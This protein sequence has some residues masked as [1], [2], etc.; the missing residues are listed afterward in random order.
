MAERVATC[1]L[2]ALGF[3]ALALSCSGAPQ[4]K[5]PSKHAPSDA[6]EEARVEKARVERARVER[7][8]V[9]KAGDQSFARMAELTGAELN[10]L[11]KDPFRRDELE[12]FGRHVYKAKGCTLCHS[13]KKGIDGG[14]GPSHGGLYG[15]RR[16]FRDGTILIAADGSYV[17]ESILEPRKRIV[18]G[19]EGVMP[20]FKGQL[21]EA[22]IEGLVAYFQSIR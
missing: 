7:A 18:K 3:A 15:S 11:I 12:A 4:A 14:I 19:Y 2:I 5:E 10:L 8:R 6:I 20:S 21:T 13:A 1:A 17:R 16:I 9:E 22:E